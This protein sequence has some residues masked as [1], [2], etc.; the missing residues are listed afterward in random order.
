MRALSLLFARLSHH[1]FVLPGSFSHSLLCLSVC[2]TMLQ[3][4][5]PHKAVLYQWGLFI[6]A[7]PHTARFTHWALLARHT[8]TFLILYHKSISCCTH[9]YK[10]YMFLQEDTQ[11]YAWSTLPYNAMVPLEAAMIAV[12]F[13]WTGCYIR[14]WGG[15]QDITSHGSP[16]REIAGSRCACVVFLLHSEDMHVRLISASKMSQDGR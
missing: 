9:F 2:W 10:K 16:R 4:V 13:A 11:K 6:R 15:A 7:S 1:P 14:S 3:L 8:W 5:W 12:V